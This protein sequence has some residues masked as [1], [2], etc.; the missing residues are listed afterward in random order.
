MNPL[1]ARSRRKAAL[2]QFVPPTLLLS[3]FLLSLLA[4]AGS[5]SATFAGT[6]VFEPGEET[7]EGKVSEL[8][9]PTTLTIRDGEK[10]WS[11]NALGSGLRT[12]FRIKVYEG[13]LYADENASLDGESKELASQT[14]YAA[15]IELHFRRGVGGDKIID[16]FR[17]D[18]KKTIP[19]DRKESL[20]ED[21]EK[22]LALFE[23]K[24]EKGDVVTLTWLPAT[25]LVI[26]FNGEEAGVI[27]NPELSTALFL[28][29]I[30]DHPINDGM[31]RDLFRLVSRKD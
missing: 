18:L 19:D 26:R 16:A 27:N 22:F 8:H 13:V 11:L 30:G 29:W 17:D 10:T 23:R 25:G 31:K 21:E 24:C 12:K 20:K 14:E 5:P 9:F 15:H 1:P 28:I 6:L 7:F 4:F 3:I 2:P